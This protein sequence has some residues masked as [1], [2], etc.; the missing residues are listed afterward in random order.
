MLYYLV[1][2]PAQTIT[3][4]NH[5]LCVIQ[6][7]AYQWRMVFNPDSTKQAN[8]VLFSCKKKHPKNHP[9]LFFNGIQVSQE[10][11]HLGLILENDF[12]FERHLEYWY[13]ETS[14]EVL[15][16]EDPRSNV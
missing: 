9:H 7:W 13:T 5:D 8:Q 3:E 2:D 6:R 11:K 10:Q 16:F 12:S 1:K 15:T 14:L 4:M